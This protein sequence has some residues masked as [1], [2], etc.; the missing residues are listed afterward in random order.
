[1]TTNPRE[2]YEEKLEVLSID[3]D[4][5]HYAIAFVIFVCSSTDIKYDNIFLSSLVSKAITAQT[6]HKTK[7]TKVS[8]VLYAWHMT[9][10]EFYCSNQRF[11]ALACF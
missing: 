7:V 8:F 11:M 4:Y 2:N 6:P 9:Y 3:F 1:M 5:L 10:H